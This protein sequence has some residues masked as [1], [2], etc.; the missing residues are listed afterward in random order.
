[1][2][3]GFSYDSAPVVTD[4]VP[5]EGPAS[6]NTSVYVYGS[7]FTSSFDTTVVFGGLNAANI[8]VIDYGTLTCSTPAHG[9][10][11]VDVTV[12]N[13]NGSGTLVDGFTYHNPPSI[14][15]VTPDN[16][17]MAGAT[18][19]T[20]TGNDFTFTGDTIVTIDGT[21][22]L[23][24]HVVNG[25]TITCE[26]PPSATPGAVDVTVVN[27]WGSDTLVDGFTYNPPPEILGITPGYGLFMGG[28]TVTLTG[29]Y[30]LPSENTEVF[31]GGEAASNI[32]V[33]D[34]NTITCMTPA[35]PVPDIVDVE[36]KNSNGMDLLSSGFEFIPESGKAPLNLTDRDTLDLYP[37]DTVRFAVTGQ[38]GALYMVFLS[39]GG[40]PVNSPWG[41]MGLDFPIYHLWTSGLNAYG[42]QTIPI[43]LEDL[44]VGFLN[45]YLQAL[46]NDSPI[47]WAVGGNNPNGSGSTKW[48]LH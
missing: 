46:V 1:M 10:G 4:V 42:Y 39:L 44:G 29:N 15:V 12:Q 48:G 40:G 18:P 11:V 24:M 6:G 17:P 21:Q 32:Q 9:A 13:T 41:V 47:V 25:T 38:P 45:F 23:N 35:Y 20:I 30:F 28:D 22:A 26:T 14:Q 16:G 31:I 27:S 8:N 43:T 2:T 19:V 34:A 5:P 37:G 36:L 7:N 3:N 33:I